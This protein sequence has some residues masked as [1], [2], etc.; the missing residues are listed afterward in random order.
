M[1]S[2]TA[3]TGVK[4]FEPDISSLLHPYVL[5]WYRIISFCLKNPQ[6]LSPIT[7]CIANLTPFKSADIWSRQHYL[8][9][10]GCPLIIRWIFF[11]FIVNLFAVWI[12]V[13]YWNKQCRRENI[14][15]GHC[16]MSLTFARCSMTPI[17]FMFFSHSMAAI[18]DT[19]NKMVVSRQMTLGPACV[20][21]RGCS[22]MTT[23]LRS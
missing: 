16:G 19:D 9:W 18:A 11:F 5:T 12:A 14:Y 23:W 10:C 21:T 2:H 4:P 8:W 6:S 13:L 15:L 1:S 3:L 7:C 20:H 17:I 22:Y